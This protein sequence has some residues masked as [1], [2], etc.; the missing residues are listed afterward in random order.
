MERHS[1]IHRV[2]IGGW[3]HEVF[4]QCLYPQPRMDSVD[5]L[6]YYA[7]F[8]DTVEVRQTFW[9]DSLIDSDARQWIDAVAESRRF[10]FNVK[11]HSSF[12]HK[13]EIKPGMTTHVRSLLQELAKNDRLG[14]LVAQF[15]FSF[16]NTGAHR[17]YLTRLSE[18]FRGFPI[19]VELRHASWDQPSLLSFLGEHSLHPV[20]ADLPHIKQYMPFVT[21]DVGKNAYLRLHGRNEKGWLLNSPDVRYDYLYNGKELRELERRIDAFSRKGT[22]LTIICNNTTGGKAVANAFQL[23]AALR[24]SKTVLIAPSALRVFPHLNPISGSFRLGESL[25]DA[26]DL[27]EAV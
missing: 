17:Y 23:I 8:F 3:E 13:K 21:G 19:H 15:P 9:D 16:T 22:R 24:K 10:V 1:V 20:S 26:S 25:L 5:K 7:Q 6:R 12:T 18:I 4:D 2:G 27:R 11:L 14:A